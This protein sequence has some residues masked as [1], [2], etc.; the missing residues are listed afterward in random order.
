MTDWV[1]IR[2]RV[3]LAGLVKDDD[4]LPVADATVTIRQAG[5][6]ETHSS[7]DGAFWFEDLS[8]GTYGIAA[9][10]DPG[11]RRG[12]AN[13]SLAVRAK[14][15]GPPPWVAVTVSARSKSQRKE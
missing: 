9:E 2:H 4:G 15:T 8:G 5:A 12:T 3:S 13:G 7:D 6:V 1:E 10:A 14:Q 11:R